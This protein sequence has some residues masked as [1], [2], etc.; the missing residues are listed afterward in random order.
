MFIGYLSHAYM[1]FL[2]YWYA[3]NVIAG[4]G[5]A[6]AGVGFG[7]GLALLTENAGQRGL[8]RGGLSESSYTKLSGM[9]MEDVEQ[10]SV[11]DLGSL[12]SQLEAALAA[13]GGINAQELEMT[14]EE[15]KKIADDSE[16][17]W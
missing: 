2:S 7:I 11:E 10:S 15:K 12:T 17:G 3:A 6:L 1:H 16:T 8:D 5:I 14:E 9:M 13:S 4:A